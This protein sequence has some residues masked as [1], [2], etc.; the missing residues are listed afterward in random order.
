M[1]LISLIISILFL[2]SCF[3]SQIKSKSYKKSEKAQDTGD[4]F[5]ILENNLNQTNDIGM[6]CRMGMYANKTIYI[7]I[8]LIIFIH[9][10]DYCNFK[11]F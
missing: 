5:R 1:Q 8:H 7:D 4:D 3:N 10:L 2:S 6:G 9:R 11:K